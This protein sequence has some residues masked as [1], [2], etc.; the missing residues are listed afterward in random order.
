MEEEERVCEWRSGFSKGSSCVDGGS[1]RGSDTEMRR[2]GP[3][4]EK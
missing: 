4:K 3:E 2:R 1:L